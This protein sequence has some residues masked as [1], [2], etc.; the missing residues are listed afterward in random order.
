MLYR[1]PDDYIPFLIAHDL[2]FAP[3]DALKSELYELEEEEFM[4]LLASKRDSTNILIKF[5]QD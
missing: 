4:V 3:F 5:E 1:G 2:N